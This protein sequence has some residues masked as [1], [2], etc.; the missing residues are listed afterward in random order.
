MGGKVCLRCKAKTLLGI[1]KKYLETESLLTSPSNVLPLHLKQTFPP[2]IWI[3][4]E[5]EGDGIKSRLPLKI[6]STLPKSR[7]KIKKPINFTVLLIAYD[8]L[9]MELP[10]MPTSMDRIT[11]AIKWH[12]L[13]VSLLYAHWENIVH[14]R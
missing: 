11:F 7:S 8:N 13:S 1:V 9:I 14:E 10:V 12:G 2:I 4:T 3:F 6:F 5:G